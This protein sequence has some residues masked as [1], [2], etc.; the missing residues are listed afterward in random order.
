MLLGSGW[1]SYK[2]P[3]TKHI[4]SILVGKRIVQIPK[5][6]VN[7]VDHTIEDL[8]KWQISTGSME[9]EEIKGGPIQGTIT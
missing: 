4:S 7:R 3:D 5:R 6:I 2:E 9:N 8:R 1:F